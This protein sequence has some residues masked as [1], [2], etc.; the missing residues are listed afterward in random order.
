MTQPAPGNSTGTAWISRFLEAQA[1]ELDAARNTQLAYGRDLKDFLAW[2]VRHD[3]GF[4]TASR[5]QIE[6]YLAFCNDQGLSAATRA[7][8]LASIRQLYRFAF[9]EKL[10]A[11]NPAIRIRG[12]RK[13]KSLPRTLSEAE[14][15]ALLTAATTH[16]RAAADRLRNTCLMEI[17]YA[18][19]LRVT[20]LV[21]LPV[22]A[23]R[24]DPQVLLVRGKGNKE[25]MVPLSTPA[26]RALTAWLAH[27]D[28]AEDLA[29]KE[30]GT[31]PSPY[32]FPS[33]AAAGH[34]PRQS[35]FLM[36]KDLCVAAGI[37]PQKVTPHTLRHAFA[38]H[39]L[40]HGADLRAIQLLLG[41]ADL[42]TTEIYTHVLETR[43]RELVLTH[44]PLAQNAPAP[45]RAHPIQDKAQT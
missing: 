45:T 2:L 16:G 26:R 14:V 37:S 25:R 8:R 18:T 34:M 3:T 19:G 29:R 32:L 44:H 1:A 12:P 10:R 21:T 31:K 33:R 27:R 42:S 30:H 9:E 20:E 7:R 6:A 17:L 23:T 38:T 35:F 43:L 13:A 15:S 11:D 36:L 40:E 41:H 22:A 5:D 28:A 24:G 39:L 4:E